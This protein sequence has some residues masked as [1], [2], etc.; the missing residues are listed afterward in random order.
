[1]KRTRIR[2]TKRLLSGP[3]QKLRT[4]PLAKANPKR[5][6]RE[7]RRSYGSGDRADWVAHQSCLICNAV[8]SE[9]AHV[10]SKSGASRKGDARWVVPLC[11]R[12]HRTGKNSLHALN[13]GGF[14][15][16]RQIDLAHEAYVTDA[17]YQQYVATRK[18]LD[19]ETT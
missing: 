3:S 2:R 16:A 10:S 5:K 12:H 1:M 19:G 8:P 17:R 9:N 13:K 14:E 15:A 7:F 18:Q 4:T 11:G 6:A